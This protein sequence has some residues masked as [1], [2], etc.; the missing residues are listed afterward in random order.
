MFEGAC[1]EFD[2]ELDRLE[3]MSEQSFEYGWICNFLDW[4]L[5]IFLRTRT[6]DNFDLVEGCEVLDQDHF[7]LEDVKDRIIEFFVVCKRRQEKGLAFEGG[8]GLGAII[9]LVGPFGVGKTL[10][11]EF[12]ARVLGRKFV[13]IFL[14]GI[15]DEVEIR[16]HQRT[17]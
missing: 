2:R 17:Y 16:E 5:D 14:G 12:V 10:L 8:R 3:W 11:G 15:Y 4:M 9:M 13:R 1:K 6:E 7:G